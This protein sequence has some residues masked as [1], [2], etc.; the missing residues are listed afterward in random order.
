MGG[1]DKVKISFIP[2]TNDG[3]IQDMNP[4]AHTGLVTYTTALADFDNNAI[5]DYLQILNSYTSGGSSKF[6]QVV[7]KIDTLINVLPGTPNV[8][9]MSDGYG[10]LDPTVAKTLAN[11]VLSKGGNLNAF[12]IGSA[13]TY[14][15]LL[16]LD[17]N[18]IQVVDINELT[19]IFSGFDDR[20]A[21]EPFMNGVTVYLD[22]NNNGQLDPGE[23]YQIT[24][25]DKTP[26]SLDTN[27]KYYFTFKDLLPGTYTVRTMLPS[28]YTMTTP[29]TNVW[30]DTITTAGETDNNLFGITQATIIPPNQDPIFV[31]TPPAITLIKANLELRYNAFARDP[32]ADIVT[33][34]L[35]TAPEGMAV[36]A[37]D[38]I[39]VWSPTSAQVDKYYQD[40]YA[41]QARLTAIGRGAYAP[42]D[43]EFNVL[44]RAT[45]SRGGQALQYL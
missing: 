35:I 5:P 13:S 9:Y 41:E 23:S 1:G 26:N 43:V 31:T 44:L 3:T 22:Q 16:E 30:T 17:P 45:D 39:V 21:K 32:D 15:T 20:Y 4:A 14:S 7:Q 42:T 11:D 25:Q 19:D 27:S 10:Y 28:G 34:D 12:A 8:I 37:H 40:L 38:G 33:Y 2:F 24:Q 6:T 36:L 29:T 18:A